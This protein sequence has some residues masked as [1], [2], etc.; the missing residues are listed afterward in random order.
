[1]RSSWLRAQEPMSS[2]EQNSELGA[3]DKYIDIVF[4]HLLYRV[5]LVLKTCEKTMM[6][7]ELDIERIER[8]LVTMNPFLASLACF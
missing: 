1:M 4:W 7:S 8:I 3:Q 5:C 6:C 2:S